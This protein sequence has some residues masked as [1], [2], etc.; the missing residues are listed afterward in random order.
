MVLDSAENWGGIA[1]NFRYLRNTIAHEHGHGL[2]LAHVCP[3]NNTKLMEPYLS[4][5][6]DGP[7][8]DE[9]RAA[10]WSYGDAYE[11]NGTTVTATG[12][13]ALAP[14]STLSPSAVPAP[15]VGGASITSIGIDGDLDHYQFTATAPLLATVTV[16][17]VGSSYADYVQDDPC[18]TSA[19]NTN[20]M[21]QADLAIDLLNAGGG[22]LATASIAGFGAA[23]TLAGHLLSPGVN[24]YVK[25]RETNS[26]AE[27]QLYTLTISGAPAPFAAGDG[28]HSDRV[29]LTWSAIAGA[30]NYA[31]YRGATPERSSAALLA[32]MSSA[33]LQYDDLTAVPGAMYS[34]WLEATT[35]G[36]AGSR[37][38]AGPETGFRA[39]PGDFNRSGDVS[40]QDIFDF[41]GAY[42]A[43]SLLADVSGDGSVSVQDIFDFLGTYFASC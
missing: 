37:A 43:G 30:T 27:T 33:A 17:P 22:T 10:Q 9:V 11:P 24:Y 19:V 18:S 6:F 31:V 40:V 15:A 38:A 2:G 34:Y 14:G 7:Q 26:P 25:V 12:L 21:N 42:F 13:G 16:A 41:L 3:R 28:T 8:Q 35:T 39:C 32:Q 29:R 23:E 1:N 5:S 36:T 4:T 20:A